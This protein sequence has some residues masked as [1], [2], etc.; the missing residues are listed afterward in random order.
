MMCLVPEGMGTCLSG[1]GPVWDQLA[2]LL[3]C[4]AVWARGVGTHYPPTHSVIQ[5]SSSEEK[6]G[7][8]FNPSA[9]LLLT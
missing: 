4:L 1:S 9:I 6:R 7:Q 5:A 3:V 2:N 8:Q